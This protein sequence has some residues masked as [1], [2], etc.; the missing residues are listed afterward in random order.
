MT[1]KDITG[2]HQVHPWHERYIRRTDELP[3][4][5]VLEKHRQLFTPN[6]LNQLEQLGDQRY[7]PGKWTAREILQHLIDT[8]RILGYRA[9]CI[10][11]GEQA[12][13]PNYD[14]A[15]YGQ[16]VEVTARSIGEL[17]SE[18][19][20]LRQ[21]N[22]LLFKSFNEAM[23]RRVGIAADKRVSVL[24][25]AYIL[26]GHPLHH[27][28]I[29]RERY[30]PLLQPVTVVA[31]VPE[32]LPYFERLNKA[33]IV[34]DFVLEHEDVYVLEHAKEAVI[35]RGGVILYA[36]DAGQVVGTVAIQPHGEEWEMI[37]MAVAEDHRKRGIGQLLIRSAIAHAKTMG[38]GRLTLHS[39][40]SSNAK[41]VALYRKLGFQEIPLGN[42]P[43]ERANIKMEIKI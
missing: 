1:K 12:H 39:N 32:Y 28:A 23:L 2:L 3:P 21:T 8:E 31:N 26:G 37:K 7:A 38:I 6:E 34:K 43:Y 16:F 22:L 4:A 18:F 14:E 10:A 24:A 40:S 41:A 33:W 30:F 25:L 5:A 35:D 11:R 36:L 27:V 29:I 19:D 15:A 13:L 20:L 17:L 42:V 9:L